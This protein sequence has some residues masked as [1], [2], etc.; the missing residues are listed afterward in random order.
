MCLHMC[1]SR[2]LKKIEAEVAQLEGNLGT[3]IADAGMRL[4]QNHHNSQALREAA[5]G[6]LTL[7]RLRSEK[8]NY[9]SLN[10]FAVKVPYNVSSGCV[11]ISRSEIGGAG[12]L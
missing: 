9:F 12:S 3:C 6:L 8:E 4:S 2:W 1:K 5:E 10:S 11:C 7:A